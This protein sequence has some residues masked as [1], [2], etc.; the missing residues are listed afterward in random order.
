MG[1]L[2]VALAFLAQSTSPISEPY[3]AQGSNSAWSL[4][5]AD[6]QITFAE[7]ARPSVSAPARRSESEGMVEYRAG[8]MTVSWTRVLDD[9]PSEPTIRTPGAAGRQDGAA[10]HRTAL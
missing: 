7:A 4:T 3:R 1:G 8:P 10:G 9:D 5:I 2:I 6:N